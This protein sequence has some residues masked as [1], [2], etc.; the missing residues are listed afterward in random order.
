VERMRCILSGLALRARLSSWRVGGRYLRDFESR[1]V[2]WQRG[3][4]IFERVSVVGVF[5]LANLQSFRF[6][7]GW[8]SAS[9]RQ[10]RERMT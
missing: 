6:L 1:E 8:E 7:E 10:S 3:L 2:V 4:V 5:E 9:V